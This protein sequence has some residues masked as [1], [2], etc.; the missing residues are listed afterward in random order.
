V[1][2]DAVA[3]VTDTLNS[4][5]IGQGPK[6]ELFESMFSEKFTTEKTCISVGS[7]TDALHL[8][9]LLAAV[10]KDSEVLVPVFTC[11]ATNI[12]FLYI[13]AK[14]K[15]VDVAENSLNMDLD[16]LER[17]ITP[18]TA[19]I[20]IVNYGGLPV[21][22][23]RLNQIA[24]RY[25]IP[26]IQDSAHALGATY[27]NQKIADLT[28]FSIYSFQAI[29]HI[30]TGDGGMLVINNPE[31]AEKAKRLRWFGIDRTS[32]LLGVWENDI[33]DVGYK[34]QMN[35]VSAAMGIAGLRAIDGYL[36][37]RRNLLNTYVQNLKSNELVR[38]I[39]AE[40]P[41][42][43]HAAWMFTIRVNNRTILQS[44]LLA[45]GIESSQVHYRNDRYSIFDGR[46][47]DLPN[48]DSIEDEYLVLPLHTKMTQSDVERVCSVINGGW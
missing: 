25:G 6:V 22:L 11:T 7:G 8:A 46:K 43:E 35:D 9:Y 12:P 30:T 48:M 18:K 39:D 2:P 10:E 38:I 31:F 47:S 20:V 33:Q 42:I 1:P 3:E 37:H 16:D 13:G 14:V 15:F 41:D 5:W 36:K 21:D 29:K 40:G 4:R 26:V 19:A 23:D 44:T 24:S 28:D 17:K 34:Y 32:K 27:K 45:Q